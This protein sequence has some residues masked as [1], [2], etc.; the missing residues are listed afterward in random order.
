MFKEASLGRRAT[1]STRPSSAAGKPSAAHVGK[2]PL[3]VGG[4]LAGASDALHVKY[5]GGVDDFDKMEALLGRTH[6]AAST[7][8]SSSS[9]SKKSSS[10]SMGKK[11]KTG[12]NDDEE[13]EEVE[14]A[15]EKKHGST[16]SS[17]GDGG[18]EKNGAETDWVTPMYMFSLPDSASEQKRVTAGLVK[19][20]AAHGAAAV[21]KN[22]RLTSGIDPETWP[23]GLDRAVYGLK[24]V[25]AHL[26]GNYLAPDFTLLDNLPWIKSINSRDENGRLRA[27]WNGQLARHVGCLFAHMTH[28]QLSKDNGL[29][30]TYLVESDGLNPLLLSV[31][32]EAVGSV[33][34][35]APKD[36]D[37]VVINQPLFAGGKLF[38][39]F[40]DKDGN[41][42]ELHEWRKQGVAGLGAYLYS[43]RFVEK[44][45]KHV[46]AHGADVVDA[47]IVDDMCSRDA[48][49]ALGTFVG[50]D[51]ETRRA[52]GAEGVAPVLRCYH[53]IG[54]QQSV[55]G[56]DPNPK[57]FPTGATASVAAA[58]ATEGKV[59][60][61]AGRKHNTRSPSSSS[62]SSSELEEQTAS[63]KKYY[64]AKAKQYETVRAL[65]AAISEGA[66][67]KSK[68]GKIL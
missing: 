13:V 18:D 4:I 31:P 9:S 53:A 1:S 16:A 26:G 21:K 6:R 49:D 56:K 64:A 63:A 59:S 23:E 43:D 50:F 14:V 33:A 61:D 60:P 35:H 29:E 34:H 11:S 38:S 8:T 2:P 7:H 41:A 12:K 44:I 25:F 66:G 57:D 15:E 54:V 20:V 39:R 27:P 68:P 24:T 36:Y 55:G 51:E 45:F 19:L 46:A 47:W 52:N 67:K 62:S 22:V 58:G 40:A 3:A 10:S 17:G 37:V 30:H 32:V 42:V 65:V 28:W 5:E 48:V